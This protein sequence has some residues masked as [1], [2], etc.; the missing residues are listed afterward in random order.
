MLL[1]DLYDVGFSSS[2]SIAF[3]YYRLLTRLYLLARCI[4]K[5]R[6]LHILRPVLCV[7]ARLARWSVH[8]EYLKCHFIYYQVMKVGIAS[9]RRKCP[10]ESPERIM[11]E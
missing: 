1:G 3:Y 10:P 11:R 9:G 7:C 6:L 2:L 5:R 8:A 4:D